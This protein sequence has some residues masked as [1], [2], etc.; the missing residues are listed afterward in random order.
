MY[1]YENSFL[2]TN[3]SCTAR[4]IQRGKGD[5][6]LSAK[7]HAP[8]AHS[9]S[10]VRPMSWLPATVRRL[11]LSALTMSFGS[12]KPPEWIE[13]IEWSKKKSHKVI[14]TWKRTEF[15]WTS[16]YMRFVLFLFPSHLCH[17]GVSTTVTIQSL[18][19]SS[20]KIMIGRFE[21]APPSYTILGRVVG[22]GVIRFFFSLFF[23]F[24]E[25]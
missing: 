15:K 7:F 4:E 13:L 20:K 3:V 10:A 23:R 18:Y 2:S 16:S 19:G 21:A 25:P 12:M 14:Q 6:T 1:I 17:I 5:N 24:Y 11:V 8:R 9:V 22:V